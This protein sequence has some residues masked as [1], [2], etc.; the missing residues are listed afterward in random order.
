MLILIRSGIKDYLLDLPSFYA[1]VS[2]VFAGISFYGIFFNEIAYIRSL[3]F[4]VINLSIQYVIGNCNQW[5]FKF[6][7]QLNNEI[8]K[9]GIQ[10][11]LMK[12]QKWI[13]HN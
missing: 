6:V 5:E 12:S 1:V 2:S 4:V 10:W 9:I 13:T 11:I 7:D 8:Y 3:K